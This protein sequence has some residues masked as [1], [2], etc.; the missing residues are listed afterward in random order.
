M[1][2]TFI[3]KQH[4]VDELLPTLMSKPAWGF[5]TETTGLDFHKD[6]VLSVQLGNSLGQFVI[7]TRDVSLEP[8]RPFFESKEVKKVAHNASFDWSMMWMNYKI[9]VEAVR[10]TMM[11]EQILNVGRKHSGYGLAKVLESR[12]EI[13]MEKEVRKTFKDH[14]GPFTQDQIEYM[15]ADVEHLLPLCQAQI[16]DLVRANL[17]KTWTV[18]CEAI[19][20]FE[21]MGLNGFKLDKEG[22]LALVKE[23]QEKLDGVEEKM[24]EFAKQWWPTDMFGEVNINYGSSPQ[25]LD[26]LHRMRVTVP[27]KN[28]TTGEEIQ[29][30]IPNTNDSMLKLVSDSPF[31]K[32]LQEHR[33]YA[34]LLST[35]G[36]SV[37]DKVRD[38]TG[39]IHFR[40]NQLGTETGRPA[41]RKGDSDYNPLNIPSDKRYRHAFIADPDYV[42]ETDDYAGQELRIW[43]HLS[44]DPGL[45]EAF[46][47]GID[48]H[49]Y[50][51]TKLF[52]VPVSKTQ[53]ADKRKLTKPM[54]FGIAYAMGPDTLYQR[55]RGDGV[56]VTRKEVQEIYD[57]Y[58]QKEF[59]TGVDYLRSMGRLALEQGYA[60]SLNDRRRYFRL[61]DASDRDK[62]PMGRADRA[63][64]A[65]EGSIRRE[66]GNAKIQMSGSDMLKRG[67]R[68]IWDKVKERRFRTE[69]KNAPYDEIVTMTH[70]DDSPEF[71]EIK[72]KMMV[73]AAEELVTSVP[74]EVEG[75][76]M[77]CWTK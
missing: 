15:G 28:K 31:V 55:M 17:T 11:A 62:Y 38:D 63:F 35:Y 6:K 59:K 54:N 58:T 3:D 77:R 1:E 37:L 41:A 9:D 49:S 46:Q 26:L 73:Q 67:M 36:M 22:W 70:K 16:A 44:Q 18:E 10:C 42:I 14:R 56:E 60:T 19:A 34:K 39:R 64:R 33:G 69:F 21:T 23:N 48:I 65:Q 45:V 68:L 12:L 32:L 8:L 13:A 50:V 76:V 57:T 71:V 40:L 29:V 24:N 66:G 25:M 47:K 20:P 7:D 51:A 2:I 72:R 43:A 27:S 53:N 5:D 4:Q 61:P 52:G 30:P 75:E 74:M